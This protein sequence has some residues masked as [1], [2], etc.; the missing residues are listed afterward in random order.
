MVRC[1]LGLLSVASCR[2]RFRIMKGVPGGTFP[3]TLAM[4][5]KLFA[6]EETRATRNP[7]SMSAPY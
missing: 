4:R 1:G 3:R 6:P 2:A 7:R 5:P